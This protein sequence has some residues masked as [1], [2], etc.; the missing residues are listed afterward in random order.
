MGFDYSIDGIDG[1]CLFGFTKIL[2]YN[3]S[4]FIFDFRTVGGI[5]NITDFNIPYRKSWSFCLGF[6]HT[7]DYYMSNCTN[8]SST[9]V[10]TACAL[11]YYVNTLGSGCT[12]C[13]KSIVGCVACDNATVCMSC[14]TPAYL[15][16]AG[17]CLT[18]LEVLTNC[19]VCVDVNVC[20]QC[21]VG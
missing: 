17:M 11:G 14:S 4:I 19:A 15:L 5:N 1:K 16:N 18:C 10:C 20:Q 7:C 6:N 2:A 13:S 3:N 8:C 12:L 21:A 9:T